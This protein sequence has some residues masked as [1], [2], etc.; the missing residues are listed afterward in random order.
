MSK[1]TSTQHWFLLRKPYD[2]CCTC[3]TASFP[4]FQPGARLQRDIQ[5]T[6]QDKRCRDFKFCFFLTK[7]T[8]SGKTRTRGARRKKVL[9]DAHLVTSSCRGAGFNNRNYYSCAKNRN[10]RKVRHPHLSVRMSVGTSVGDFFITFNKIAWQ[11]VG[12]KQVRKYNCIY[13]VF[14]PREGWGLAPKIVKHKAV[15]YPGIC[16]QTINTLSRKIERLL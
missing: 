12:M 14:L 10:L 9:F 1:G 5:L 16:P 3:C 6:L 4:V 2:T 15:L 11:I 13:T 8:T 7:A